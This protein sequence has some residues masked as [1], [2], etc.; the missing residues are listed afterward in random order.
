MTVSEVYLESAA[1]ATTF[2]TQPIVAARW[3]APSALAKLRIGGLTAH[4][5]G[6]LTQVPPALDAPVV[7]RA[8]RWP[9]ISRC[10]PGRTAIS[11]AT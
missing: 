1:V 5:V 8:S 4:L 2:L 10:R 6:Q 9:S 3:D 11:R 7:D